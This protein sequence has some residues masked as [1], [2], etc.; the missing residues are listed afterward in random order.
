MRQ[1]QEI[2]GGLRSTKVKREHSIR[3]LSF[4]REPIGQADVSP[5]LHSHS[6]DLAPKMGSTDLSSM[7]IAEDGNCFTSGTLSLPLTPEF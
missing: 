3:H 7:G 2:S 5:H 6:Q 1:G 4:L